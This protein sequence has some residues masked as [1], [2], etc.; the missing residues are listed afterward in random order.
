MVSLAL[1]HLLIWTTLSGKYYLDLDFEDKEP[2]PKV[3]RLSQDR[4]GSRA[5]PG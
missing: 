4:M 1:T 5:E 2:E 3:K